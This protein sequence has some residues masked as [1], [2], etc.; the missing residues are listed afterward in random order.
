[1]WEAGSGPALASQ[2]ELADS[3]DPARAARA[4]RG[5]AS[6]EDP[7]PTSRGARGGRPVSYLQ[8]PGAHVS[9]ALLHQ[10][11]SRATTA[12]LSAVD[13]A[14]AEPKPV[15]KP[16]CGDWRGCVGPWRLSAAS[17][18]TPCRG[19]QLAEVESVEEAR[20]A[21]RLNT[22]SPKGLFA[23]HLHA[24]LPPVRRRGAV[25]LRQRTVRVH[26]LVT[27]ALMR[28]AWGVPGKGKQHGRLAVEQGQAAAACSMRTWL[29]EAAKLQGACMR[30]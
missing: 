4:A 27:V 10:L 16:Y 7:S 22:L 1:M 2:A 23:T 15:P 26:T 12:V 13:P 19:D 18:H 21:G 8:G 25:R 29:S 20:A 6:L 14:G 5:V 17:F 24:R 3:A 30:D 9:T 11:A 28:G